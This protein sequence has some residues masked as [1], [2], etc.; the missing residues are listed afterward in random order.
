[1]AITEETIRDQIPFY[2]TQ[3]QKQSLAAGLREFEQSSTISSFSIAQYADETL[4]GDGWSKFQIFNFDTGIRRNVRGMVISNSCDIDPNNPRDTPSKITFVPLIPL[5][6]LEQ[7]WL[8]NGLGAER[9]NQKLN[10]IRAQRVTDFFYIP[11]TGEL[12]KESVAILHD[13]HTMPLDALLDTTQRKKL[14]TLSQVA[15]YLL[16][17]K[18]SVHFCR[19]HENVSR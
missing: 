15:F 1:M 5:G 3:P 16:L 4:Q 18:L 11:Q 2:L 7:L 8:E 12:E 10:D 6:K 9:L 19:M 17:F 13:V 14:F